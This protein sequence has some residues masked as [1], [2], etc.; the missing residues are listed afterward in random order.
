[1]SPIPAGHVA[2]AGLIALYGRRGWRGVLI[3]GPSG[4]GK[5][6]LALRSLE[7]GFSLVSDD[8]TLLWVSQGRLFGACPPTIAGLIEAR[9]VGVSPRPAR[10]FCEISL[11]VQCVGSDTP[12]ERIPVFASH[13][14]LGVACPTLDL[15]PLEASSPVKLIHALSL[16]GGER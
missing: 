7:A 6:D 13:A 16:L 4:I 14:I 1:M 11:V 2:H 3:Q 12:V 15:R 5:S 8:R 9:G 10:S